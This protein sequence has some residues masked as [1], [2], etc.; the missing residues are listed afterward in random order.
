MSWTGYIGVLIS[1]LGF[2]SNFVPLKRVKIG[3]GIFFQ[4]IMCNAI[5]I[6]AIP[7]LIVQKFPEM[8]GLALLGGFLWCTGNILCPIVIRC[9]GMGLGLLVWGCISM[10]MGWAS[11]R[12]GLF[13]LHKQVIANPDLNTIGMVLA[14]IGLLVFLQVQTNDTSV[15]NM[16]KDG[17]VTSPLVLTGDDEDQGVHLVADSTLFADKK[18]RRNVQKVDEADGDSNGLPFSD[19][20]KRV[21]GLVLAAVA[22]I[23]FGCSFD[24]SQYVIDHKYDGNDNS[25]N[26][27]FA[28]YTGILITSWFYTIAYCL[29]KGYH[30]QRP[31]INADI[32]LPGTLSGLMWGIA[33]CAWFYANGQLGFA[34]TFPIISCGP[35]FVGSLWGIFLFKEITGF[36]NLGLLGLAALITVPALIVVGLSA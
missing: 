25:L 16:A 6:T 18:N 8:H 28:H 29:Y 36:R 12:F 3:D 23:F 14:I 10:I 27:V 11:G 17:D 33:Q 7:V 15:D 30:N 5:F 35:G 1:V 32:L 24:P 9:I 19:S 34:V 26:Y 21:A 20:T 4:F 2:G 22:G 31:Y 13:G